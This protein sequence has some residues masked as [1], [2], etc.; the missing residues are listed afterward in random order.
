M[1]VAVIGGAGQMGAWFIDYFMSRGFPT[2]LS[3]VRID[4]ARSVASIVGAEL[5][6]TNII[7]V[8]NAGIVLVCVPIDK[9][10]EVI[11]E[12]M[13]HM[14]RG[15]ILTEVSS[16]KER[17]VE[18][19]SEATSFGVRPLSIHPMFGPN[20]ES[21]RGKTIV[22]IPVIDGD[23]ELDLAKNLFEEADI[24]VSNHRE[25][26]AVMAVVLSL[27][28][29]INLAFARVL[30]PGDLL[31]T[32]RLAGTTFT[33]QLALAE[34]VV[35][36]DPYLVASLFKE[37]PFTEQYVDRFIDEAEMIKELIKERTKDFIELYDSLRASIEKDPDFK[38]ADERRRRAF[39]ALKT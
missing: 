24:V 39:E 32:K 33:I 9:T 29:L 10:P 30:S 31:S 18:A 6:E 27:T 36:E 23:I 22:V 12:I 7:A 26:D 13:P 1:K 14:M 16:I 3:D 17:A 37:N 4:K 11:S 19:M 20:A 28:Y 21:I 5:A 2:V 34:S 8:K 38:F 25:H 35:S 15:S